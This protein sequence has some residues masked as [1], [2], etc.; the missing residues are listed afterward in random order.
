MPRPAISSCAGSRITP[1]R[2]SRIRLPTPAARITAFRRDE[3]RC[4]SG[5]AKLATEGLEVQGLAIEPL[6]RTRA[7][8]C[9][10]WSVG[11]YPIPR[12]PYCVLH[13]LPGGIATVLV[14]VPA[15]REIRL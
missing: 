4:G 14:A 6:H 10:H 13:L 15:P 2:G 7:L 9:A 1:G 12:V 8:P 3:F 11:G 5:I